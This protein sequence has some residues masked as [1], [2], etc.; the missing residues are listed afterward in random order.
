M[1][2]LLDMKVGGHLFARFALSIGTIK[3][4]VAV[5]VKFCIVFLNCY[6]FMIL[7]ILQVLQFFKARN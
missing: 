4:S 5:E 2:F 6:I 1:L 7:L 3:Y